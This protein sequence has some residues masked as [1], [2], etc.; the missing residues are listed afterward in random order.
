MNKLPIIIILTFILIFATSISVNALS[1]DDS[2]NFYFDLDDDTVNASG[3]IELTNSNGTF[4]SAGGITDQGSYINAT[5]TTMV[6]GTTLI[7]ADAQF[8]PID[9][10]NFTISF[11]YQVDENAD[12]AGFI[13]RRQSSGDDGFFAYQQPGTGTDHFWTDIGTF[14][15]VAELDSEINDAWALFVITKDD[16]N[17][18]IYLNDTLVATRTYGTLDITKGL[19]FLCGSNTADCNGPTGGRGLFGRIDEIAIWT[20]TLD[21]ANVTSLWND[22]NGSFFDLSSFE[23]D[24]IFADL[25]NNATEQTGNGTTVQFNVN[26]TSKSNT[27]DTCWFQTNLSGAFVNSTSG[28]CSSTQSIVFNESVVVTSPVGSFVCGFAG[29][30]ITNGDSDESAQSCF[31]VFENVAPTWENIGNNAT[32]LFVSEQVNW[33]VTLSDETALFN[34]TFSHNASGSFVNSTPV[35]ISGTSHLANGEATMPGT[36][37]TTVCALFFFEDDNQ[38]NQTDLNCIVTPDLIRVNVS[39][40]EFQ[41]NISIDVFTVLAV[42][43]DVSFNLSQSTTSG[44]IFL[45]LPKGNFSF[46]GSSA[47]FANTTENRSITVGTNVTLFF[48]NS[49]SIRLFIFDEIRRVPLERNWTVE[50]IGD[51]SSS[52]FTSETNVTIFDLQA[53]NYTLR[54]SATDYQTR[55]FFI[56]LKEGEAADLILFSLT[57]GNSSSITI[58]VDDQGLVGVEGAIVQALRF[59]LSLNAFE[60]VEM[61]KTNFEGKT[62]LHLEKNNEF[63]QFIILFNNEIKLISEGTIIRDS[64]VT[65][66]LNFKIDII[67]N[68]LTTLD[69][70]LAVPTSLTY[71]NNTGTFRFTFADP[72]GLTKQGCLEVRRIAIL[73]LITL[74]ENC[75][76]SSSATILISINNTKDGSYIGS[77]T[78]C[79]TTAINN[80]CFSTGSVT[81][82]INSRAN[83]LREMGAFVSFF[84]VGIMF[85][86]GLMSGVMGGMMMGVMGLIFVTIAGF[87][88]LPQGAL[89]AL[90]ILVITIGIKAK[91]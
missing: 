26:I 16:T 6:G 38:R 17:M 45:D 62:E 54:Y 19:A 77:G 36:V 86:V 10:I 43:T 51:L 13:N 90:I 35:S 72:T 55:L 47:G 87:V 58:S 69:N 61:G 53:D 21:Q 4:L 50:V 67:E 65:L 48:Q 29:A 7:L 78:I 39:A 71:N 28:P 81:V 79:T 11:W 5:S 25:S 49:S 34:Y 59:R 41:G 33:T 18:R 3:A 14:D 57:T 2:L 88:T 89:I 12:G 9:T 66:G 60:I 52:N 82:T 20:R 63:Y 46:V 73:G 68:V 85:M 70:L 56:E 32:G 31:F 30:N 22:G 91:K 76:V 42:G 83:T 23:G 40:Q 8:A 64:D 74:E 75:V 80:T 37:N 15:T 27:L 44:E 24:I 84:I 1:L